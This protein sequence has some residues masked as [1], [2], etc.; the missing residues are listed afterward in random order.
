MKYYYHYLIILFCVIVHP[1]DYTE[2][3]DKNGGCEQ[4]CTENGKEPL[5]SCNAP[6][7]KLAADKKKCLKGRCNK[8]NSDIY[9]LS[10]PLTLTLTPL[11]SDVITRKMKLHTSHV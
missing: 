6:A 2:G 11:L 5:C 10:Y 9:S 1:C 7:F 4:T 3:E 8:F